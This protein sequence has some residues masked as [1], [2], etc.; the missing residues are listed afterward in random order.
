MV[1]VQINDVIDDENKISTISTE[2]ED[3]NNQLSLLKM[4]MVKRRSLSQNGRIQS[5]SKKMA[6][7]RLELLEHMEKCTLSPVT[8]SSTL[9]LQ[10]KNNRLVQK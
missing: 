8:K 1:K 10:S 5:A 9:S 4:A 2:Q 7:N 3:I 6:S